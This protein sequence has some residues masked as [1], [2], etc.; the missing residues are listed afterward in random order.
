MLTVAL[1]YL[2]LVC[3]EAISFSTTINSF[4]IGFQSTCLDFW[5]LHSTSF[6]CFCQAH[7]SVWLFALWNDAN[8]SSFIVYNHLDSA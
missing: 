3:K 7:N 1:D 4:T 6:P 8:S 2:P 5:F